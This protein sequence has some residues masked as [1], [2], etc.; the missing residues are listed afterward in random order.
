MTRKWLFLLCLAFGGSLFAQTNGQ[1]DG[2]I[3]D[4]SG[5]LIPGAEITTVG[6][7]QGEKRTTISGD[8]GHFVFPQLRPETYQV[9]VTLPGFTP[10]KTTI[11]LGV[12]QSRSIEVALQVQG[13]AAELDVIAEMSV[14]DVSSARLGANI[15][16]SEVVALPI[17]GRTYSFL[18]LSAPGASN[19]S[20]APSTKSGSTER[21]Q[22]RTSLHSMEST[23]RRFSIRPPAG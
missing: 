4:Q 8:A 21:R 7:A 17:N 10:F 14:I 19:T 13:A 23:R 5:A 11:Q 9:E 1:I 6:L 18:A 2:V 3:K 20:D 12:G 22:S 16:A 15:G